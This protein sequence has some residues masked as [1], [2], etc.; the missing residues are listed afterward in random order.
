MSH[1]N[2]NTKR[3]CK[4]DNQRGADGVDMEEIEGF[5]AKGY[6]KNAVEGMKN[7]FQT[8]LADA[9]KRNDL[10]PTVPI[11]FFRHIS[12]TGKEG[13]VMAFGSQPRIK[14]LTMCL[15]SSLDIGNAAHSKNSDP[16]FAIIC[17]TLLS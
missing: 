14:C 10:N 9:P 6:V 1:H 7:R 17:H 3:S 15:H 4:R 13:D 5:S 2:G 12:L 11:R 8:L 16:K